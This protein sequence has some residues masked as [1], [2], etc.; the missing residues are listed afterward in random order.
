[1]AISNDVCDDATM[2]SLSFFNDR[3][4]EICSSGNGWSRWSP[5]RFK[6][7]VKTPPKDLTPF[8]ATD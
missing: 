3:D 4:F 1:M 8:W 7:V 6:N 5:F 2:C